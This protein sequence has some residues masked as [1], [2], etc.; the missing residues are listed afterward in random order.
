MANRVT[1][2]VA[3]MLYQDDKAAGL[4]YF[5]MN[6][7]GG[8]GASNNHTKLMMKWGQRLK[9]VGFVLDANETR[10]GRSPTLTKEEVMECAKEFMNGYFVKV[11]GRT[12]TMWRGFTSIEDAWCCSDA[13]KIRQ[14]LAETGIQP[15]TLW[16]NMLKHCPLIEA[17]KQSVDIKAEL[18]EEVKDERRK[19][20]GQLRRW[21]Q[22]KLETVVWIDAK[23]LYI[24]PGQLKVYGLSNNDRVVVDSRMKM[25]KSSTGVVL[26]YYSAVNALEGVIDLVWVTGTTDLSKTRKPGVT[27]VTT[28]IVT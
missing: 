15:R 25:G 19:V 26:H 1:A 18:T 12:E 10:T 8:F 21:P 20:A 4:S 3:Y 7:Q 2:A 5:A 14:H 24:A 23:K 9:E 6:A 13:L 11:K 22:V 28:Y 27:K 16:R 17:C